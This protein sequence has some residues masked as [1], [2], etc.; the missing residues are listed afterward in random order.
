MANFKK[1]CGIADIIFYII[2][3]GII[4][5]AWKQA[6]GKRWFMQKKPV[7][8]PSHNAAEQPDQKA[9]AL[10][11]EPDIRPDDGLWMQL[12]L[13]G[14]QQGNHG[15]DIR[16]GA[17]LLLKRL[18]SLKQG[19]ALYAVFVQDFYHPANPEGAFLA[20]GCYDSAEEAEA[21]LMNSGQREP[22]LA[23]Q[24]LS[25]NHKPPEDGFVPPPSLEEYEVRTHNCIILCHAPSRTKAERFVV[26]FVQSGIDKLEP[27]DAQAEL[28]GCRFMSMFCRVCAVGDSEHGPCAEL[29]RTKKP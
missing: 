6:L 11:A 7:E 2:A 15:P 24:V 26:S 1:I 3:P 20:I 23:V 5:N 17:L 16:S 25:A 21:A 10:P 12:S 18:G 28:R 22:G 27:A 8:E 4:F 13:S 9:Q 29:R 14:T 19:D